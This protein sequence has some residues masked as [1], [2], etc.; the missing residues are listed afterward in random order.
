[1]SNAFKFT[2]EGEIEVALRQ[3]AAG[4]ELKVR[5][6]LA[7]FYERR[8]SRSFPALFVTI[9]PSLAIGAVLFTPVNFEGLVK[10]AVAIT[11]FASNLFFWRETGY[12]HE[13]AAHKPIR[14]PEGSS[15][16]WAGLPP[17]RE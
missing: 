6:T 11:L 5:Y 12:F 9:A 15:R 16:W 13:P 4:F 2:F 8:I 14:R 17:L 10:S 3:R 1:M 7:N